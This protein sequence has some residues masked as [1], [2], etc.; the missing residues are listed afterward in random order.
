[1]KHIVSLCEQLYAA[2]RLIKG[3]HCW[4]HKTLSWMSSSDGCFAATGTNTQQSSAVYCV[5][6]IHSYPLYSV[7]R[8]FERAVDIIHSDPNNFSTLPEN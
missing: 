2:D 3:L 1:M 6:Q 8:H 7:G 4:Q 5:S